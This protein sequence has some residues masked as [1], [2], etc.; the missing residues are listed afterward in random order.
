[1]AVRFFEQPITIGLECFQTACL[2]CSLALTSC[3]SLQRSKSPAVFFEETMDS[4]LICSL[5]LHVCRRDWVFSSCSQPCKA[6][7]LTGECQCSASLW[8]TIKGKSS[9]CWQNRIAV[10]QELSIDYKL[11]L[12][13]PLLIKFSGENVNGKSSSSK[14]DKLVLSCMPTARDW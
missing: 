9:A 6:L 4:A 13:I 10:L 7:V 3:W 2:C 1:M 12:T 11:N 8:T 14:D 5:A